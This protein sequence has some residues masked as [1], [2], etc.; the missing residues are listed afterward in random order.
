MLWVFTLVLCAPALALAGDI[1]A[2]PAARAACPTHTA[3]RD[4]TERLFDRAGFALRTRAAARFRVVDRAVR[5][6]HRAPAYVDPIQDERRAASARVR[7]PVAARLAA[8]GGLAPVRPAAGR[9]TESPAAAQAGPPAA[10]AAPALASAAVL[11]RGARY[12]DRVRVQ[13]GARRIQLLRNGQIL[14]TFRIALGRN[15]RGH[16]VRQGDG[17]TP[18]GTYTLDRR[19]PRSAFYRSIHISYPGAADVARSR[20]TGEDPG[21]QIMI[22]GLPNG[23]SDVGS[24][25]VR[26]DWTE[27]CIAVTNE[28]MDQIWELVRDGTP[29]EIVP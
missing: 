19:N 25:H 1:P 5:A 17:R 27:G 18:E 21:G 9:P 3:D 7:S 20:S 12:A 23:Q 29:I 26:R 2:A 8:A 14:A 6:A 28:E 24:A 13:K 16:K 15:P 22:H 10:P 4:A 11:D